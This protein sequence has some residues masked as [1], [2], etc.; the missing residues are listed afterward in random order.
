MVHGLRLERVFKVVASFVTIIMA[1]I[2]FYYTTHSMELA[3]IFIALL[4]L[5]GFNVI[6][7]S[8]IMARFEDIER[9]MA[10]KEELNELARRLAEVERR[11]A[12]KDALK[13]LGITLLEGSQGMQEIV[14]EFM[15]YK[16]VIGV[17]EKMT[18]SRILSRYQTGLKSVLEAIN[19]KK[20]KVTR[21]ELE[22]IEKIEKGKID[23]LTLEDCDVLVEMYKRWLWEGV[24][25]AGLALAAAIALRVIV[26][27]EIETRRREE[28]Q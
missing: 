15:S 20:I 6:T 1:T 22:V 2:A 23:D 18:I 8:D 4:S 27:R 5:A 9:R 12:T 14:L 28:I 17:E 16:G 24:K 19:P 13:K 3:I 7:Y 21:R 10:T 11:M 25:G 26:R